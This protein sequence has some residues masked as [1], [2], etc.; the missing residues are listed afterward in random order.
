MNVQELFCGLALLAMAS[1]VLANKYIIDVQGESPNRVIV[2]ADAEDIARLGGSAFSKTLIRGIE[3]ELVYEAADK[4]NWTVMAAQ[5]ECPNMNRMNMPDVNGSNVRVPK[6]MEVKLASL[7]EV[8][9]IRFRS[10]GGG[11]WSRKKDSYDA[12]Q[13]TDWQTTSSYTLL[14][15]YRIACQPDAFSS[16]L[17]ASGNPDRSINDGLLAKNMEGLGLHGLAVV[18]I[19]PGEDAADFTWKHIWK[20]AVRPP[21]VAARKMT[22][23]EIAGLKRNMAQLKSKVDREAD[24]T[25]ATLKKLGGELSFTAKAAQL[26]GKRK[27]SLAE[28][29][30]VQV[31]VGKTEHDV[32]VANGPPAINEAGG[33]RFLS[34]GSSYD[35]QVQWVNA[36][37]GAPMGSAGG[38]QYCNVRYVLMPDESDNVYKVAD[39][40]VAAD[41]AGDTR[42]M[43]AC[44]NVMNTPG[45]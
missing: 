12:M 27:L 20:D 41:S 19:G 10:S 34:Y 36:F 15:A 17:Q 39:V 33:M 23:A 45:Q 24:Q 35:N 8:D 5:F 4:P 26:R 2:Y 38:W 32:V 22:P 1:P 30:L 18:P 21:S 7:P 31:W 25:N 9:T 13:P 16:A 37:N 11:T 14:Q 29:T 6:D 42:G 3:L 44:A 43:H 28:S 40:R